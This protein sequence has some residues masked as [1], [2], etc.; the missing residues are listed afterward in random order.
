VARFDPTRGRIL[1]NDTDIRD[2]RL[3]TY[4]DLLAIVPQDVFLSMGRSATTSPT[5]GT[6]RPTLKSKMRQAREC[7]R[8]HRQL[9]DPTTRSSVSAA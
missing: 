6:M 2:F 8:I 4:R 5:A 7:P 9:P 1:V 3:K